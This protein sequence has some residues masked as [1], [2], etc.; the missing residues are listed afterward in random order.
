ML[1]RSLRQDRL[2]VLTGLL[3]TTALA[4]LYLLN[5]AWAMPQD[6]MDMAQMGMEMAMPNAAGWTAADLW[7]TFA[8]WSVM[9]V[10]MMLPAAAPM[11]LTYAALSRQR[12]TRQPPFA[13]TALFLLGYIIVWVGFAFAA[14]VAQGL[15][16]SAALLSSELAV[17]SSLAGGVC[18]IIAGLFQF[19]PLKHRCL[20]HCRTPLGFLLGEWRVG[21]WG[22]LTMGVRH[23]LYCLGCCWAI[24]ALLFVA[25]VMNLLWVAA[26]AVFV[27]AE[28]LLPA[29]PWLARIAGVLFVLWGLWLIAGARWM[30]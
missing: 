22:A 29:G 25:G 15:L 9:M 16:H 12:A 5:L 23:G 18:L 26:L 11:I 13:P 7:L 1:D 19:T 24:M 6:T 14:T 4:W 28:K 30:G 2:V 17:T 3:A 27:F 20:H 21:E 8:M 10:A